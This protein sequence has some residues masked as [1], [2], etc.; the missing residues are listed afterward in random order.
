MCGHFPQFRIVVW[1]IE[2]CKVSPQPYR[3]IPCNQTQG[4][5]TMYRVSTGLF[6]SLFAFSSLAPAQVQENRGGSSAGQS[7]SQASTTSAGNL[8]V[9][10]ASGTVRGEL[11]SYGASYPGATW[12][13][14]A[15]DYAGTPKPMGYGP[16]WPA[17]GNR[18]C[19][20]FYHYPYVYYPQNFYSS[21][22]YRSSDSMYYRY[23]PEM[24]I[25]VYNKHWHNYYPSPRRYHWGHHFITD[26]F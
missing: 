5:V 10:T 6:L 4:E 11:A 1:P 8:G 25:P 2:N 22:Y 21:D 7:V 26:V 20:R 15:G 23:P 19:S 18:D 16:M 9:T 12:S 3:M 17:T 13:T 24:Q 14:S